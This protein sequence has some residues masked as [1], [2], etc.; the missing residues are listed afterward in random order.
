MQ[1]ILEKG[2]PKQLFITKQNQLA[3]IFDHISRLKHQDIWNFPDKYTQPDTNFRKQLLKQEKLE[4]VKLS[5]SPF[6][7]VETLQYVCTATC[8]NFLRS[9][10]D[11]SK[12]DWIEV[13]FKRVSQITS[14]PE[15]SYYGLF[16]HDTS[17]I[18]SFM[19][20]PAL[21]KFTILA[22]LSGNVFT[23]KNVRAYR[24]ACATPE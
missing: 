24:T 10:H 23:L 9:K 21:I 6:G 17:I 15:R 22:N 18:L 1:L 16:V 13:T 3:R 14:L 11:M 2:S 5:K 8:S 7:T 12:K 4:D 19:K 20:H